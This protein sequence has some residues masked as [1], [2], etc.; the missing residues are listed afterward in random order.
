LILFREIARRGHEIGSHGLNH[1]LVSKL[2]LKEFT[3]D[4]SESM[5]RLEDSTQKKIIY[6]R[7]P[8]WSISKENLEVLTILEG[9]GIICDSSLQPFQTPLSGIDGL[10]IEPYVPILNGRALNLIE[11]P[12][13]VCNLTNN[14]KVSYAGGFYLR[15]FPYWFIHGMLKKLNKLREGMV[16]IHPWEIQSNIPK[17]KA[18]AH[19]KFIQYYNLTSTITKLENLL[20]D[21]KFSSLGEVIHGRIYPEKC[22]DYV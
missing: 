10:P 9:K 5:A 13:T 19:L 20:R 14:V 4:L 17:V 22:L 15:F 18:L 2:S 7:A 8:S 16:Y 21:F 3:N 6:Y 1:Q 11:F 12:P